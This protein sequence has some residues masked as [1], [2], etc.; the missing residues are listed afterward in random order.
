MS[1][2]MP[3]APKVPRKR[4]SG[5]DP[6]NSKTSMNW[7]L[8]RLRQRISVS[9]SKKRSAEEI[10]QEE[11]DRARGKKW[12]NLTLAEQTRLR[13]RLLATLL[14]ADKRAP[15]EPIFA[16]ISN[17]DTRQAA[18]EAAG[19]VVDLSL[20]SD[21]EDVPRFKQHCTILST[22][23]IK[24]AFEVGKTY[25]TDKI[26]IKVLERLDIKPTPRIKINSGEWKEIYLWRGRNRRDVEVVE[27]ESSDGSSVKEEVLASDEIVEIQIDSDDDLDLSENEFD[28]ITCPD[29]GFHWDGNAQHECM[30]VTCILFTD[31]VDPNLLGLEWSF[32]QGTTEDAESIEDDI[33]KETVR[34]SAKIWVVRTCDIDDLMSQLENNGLTCEEK[35]DDGYT[36]VY[37]IS[38][39]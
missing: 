20:E 2:F 13:R 4:W 3:A 11:I 28:G 38:K 14:R 37:K 27:F 17:V 24:V 5:A 31:D 23:R 21:G 8:H 22:A 9:R 35:Y 26:K 6:F 25:E 19:Q 36:E 16:G 15:E 30:A 32:A 12:R 34:E 29:C 18:A 39:N 33:L 1:R 7:L 10:L